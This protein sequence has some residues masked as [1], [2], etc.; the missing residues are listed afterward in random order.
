MEWCPG[1]NSVFASGGEDDQI[2]LW[3]LAVEREDDNEDLTVSV[4][5]HLYIGS[6][7]VRLYFFGKNDVMLLNKWP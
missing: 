7:F 1:E 5:T 4:Q 2:A 3:D 6:N